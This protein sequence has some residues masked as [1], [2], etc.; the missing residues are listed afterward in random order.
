[1]SSLSLL[2]LL[3]EN[4]IMRNQEQIDTFEGALLDLMNL[5]S[6]HDLMLPLLLQAFDDGTRHPE[7]MEGLR[8]EV[9]K[10][11]RENP[12]YFLLTVLEQTPFV[13]E[14]A[15][16]WLTAFY[17]EF[18]CDDHMKSELKQALRAMPN[19][20]RNVIRAYMADL[21]TTAFHQEIT[22]EL[23]KLRA[24]QLSVPDKMELDPRTTRMKGLIIKDRKTT[25][26]GKTYLAFDLVD[27]LQVIEKH[28]RDYLWIISKDVEANGDT[29]S[30]IEGFALS[31]MRISTSKL[32]ELSRGVVQIIDGTFTAYDSGDQIMVIIRA[33]DSTVYDVLSDNLTILEAIRTEFR[34]VAPYVADV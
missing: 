24:D 5:R 7:V 1:M 11:Y 6:Q 25:W 8:L 15:A 16:G 9:E 31:E 30:E 33:V 17:L 13:W 4:R 14:R 20:V 28:V 18:I 19:P 27:I 10:Y 26:D 2:R 32:L 23:E 3:I 22:S 29:A 21:P 34:H 12:S